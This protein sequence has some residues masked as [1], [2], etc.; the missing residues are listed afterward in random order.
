MTNHDAALLWATDVLKRLYEA[1]PERI[2][3]TMEQTLV[4][5]G[6]RLRT[7]E[8][9][10]WHD[11]WLWLVE[12]GLVRIEPEQVKQISKRHVAIEQR[13]DA[14]VLTGKGL[15]TFFKEGEIKK[16]RIEVPVLIHN[17]LKYS[18][19]LDLV[20]VA[21][22]FLC[23]SLAGIFIINAY[24]YLRDESMLYWVEHEIRSSGTIPPTYW[25]VNVCYYYYPVR[26]FFVIYEQ[27]S[28]RACPRTM[29]INSGFSVKQLQ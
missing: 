19:I 22:G 26:T 18:I 4:A 13:I 2:S 27:L 24:L 14:A 11:L 29:P 15:D 21:F 20:K 16:E 5:T 25:R 9:K 6:A 8:E 3:L 28:I 12:E 10:V 7:R 1:W 23:V 17:R